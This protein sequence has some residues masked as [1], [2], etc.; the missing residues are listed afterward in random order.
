MAPCRNQRCVS[1]RISVRVSMVGIAFMTMPT[2]FM[3][4]RLCVSYAPSN[5]VSVFSWLPHLIIVN[6]SGDGL[7]VKTL[8]QCVL[9]SRA[10]FQTRSVGGPERMLSVED[11]E[12]VSSNLTRRVCPS[13]HLC[14]LEMLIYCH[15]VGFEMDVW[16]ATRRLKIYLQITTY[17][18]LCTEMDRRV[19]SQSQLRL[20]AAIAVKFWMFEYVWI[21]ERRN[22]TYE[23][24]MSQVII[25][26]TRMVRMTT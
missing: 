7:V 17:E 2:F 23:P 10:L 26:S 25:Y 6:N 14:N 11:A 15:T 9:Q 8:R 1:F 13:F 19:A 3:A 22:R 5:S 20:T 16:I 12:I 21:W 24:R 18:M 4:C